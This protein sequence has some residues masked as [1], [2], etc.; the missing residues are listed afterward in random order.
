MYLAFMAYKDLGLSERFGAGDQLSGPLMNHLQA[1]GCRRKA[2]AGHLL[3]S[4][5]GE[6]PLDDCLV[7]YDAHRPDGKTALRKL[8]SDLYGRAATTHAFENSALLVAEVDSAKACVEW[9]DLFDIDLGKFDR[10]KTKD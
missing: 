4:M 8:V 9:D 2:E 7:Q 3:M 6:R 1:L 5:I 10:R